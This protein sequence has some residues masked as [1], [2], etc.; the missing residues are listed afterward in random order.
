MCTLAIYFQ[1]FE[2][3]PLTLAANR[4]EFLSRPSAPPQV[5]AD[6]PLVFGGKDLLAGG[7][8]LGVNEHGLL[9]GI[10]NRRSEADKKMVQGRSRG[11]LCL[12]VLKTRDPVRAVEYLRGVKASIYQSFNLLFANSKEAYA[13]YNVEERIECV[14]LR[15]GVHVL[16][17]SA[18][19]GGPSEKM[20]HSKNLFNDARRQIAQGVTEPSFFK[21]KFSR[22]LQVWDQP[23]MVHLFKR[24][25]SN[26]RLGEGPGDPR[27]AICV[28]T[29]DYGTVSS[30][31]IFYSGNERQFHFYHASGPPCR[32]EYERFLPVGVL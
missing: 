17:N 9:V 16:G 29:G 13:A 18:I 10:V 11:L 25:L 12:D 1:E 24:V 27:D 31:M 26:H 19:Y 15:K 6:N 7:T 20:V 21:R 22:G 3:Y 8:W 28:H 5:L 2:T 4:D 32:S 23:S 30:T 14:R